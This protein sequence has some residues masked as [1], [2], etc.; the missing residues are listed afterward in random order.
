M[1]KNNFVA[2]VGLTYKS[3]APPEGLPQIT[4]PDLAYQLLL[5]IWDKDTI[6]LHEHFVVL[7]LNNQ[8]Q[9]LGWSTISKGGSTSTVVDP[10]HIFQLALLANS[11]SLVL[12][13]NHP[14][15]A[16]KASTADIQLT[17]RIKQAGDLLG[18][19]VDDHLIL[20]R[21]GYLSLKSTGIL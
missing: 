1:T 8:K 14:G 10:R 11:E 3:I 19:T 17:K 15:R 9:C 18:I 4:S 16:L 5:S 6:E 20:T 21:E 12:A 2:E 7:M 13:H